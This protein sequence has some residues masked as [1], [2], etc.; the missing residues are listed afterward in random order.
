MISNTENC[1]N[2]IDIPPSQTYRSHINILLE[3]FPSL[4]SDYIEDLTRAIPRN[5]SWRPIVLRDIKNPTLCRQL[6]HSWR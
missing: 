5:R 3:G 4:G 6:S 2:Y 1:V